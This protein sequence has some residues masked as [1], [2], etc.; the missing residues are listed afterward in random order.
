MELHTTNI[1]E[2]LS[3]FP[4]FD[5]SF[6]DSTDINDPVIYQ[7]LVEFNELVA[8][9]E[10]NSSNRQWTFRDYFILFSKIVGVCI[11]IILFYIFYKLFLGNFVQ[12]IKHKIKSMSNKN[13]IITYSFFMGIVFLLGVFPLPG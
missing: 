4:N 3:P 9:S 1:Q 10:A 7:K 2:T 11:L 5:K 6:P 8:D 13:G 12:F